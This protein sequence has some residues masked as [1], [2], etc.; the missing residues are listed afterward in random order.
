MAT[1]PVTTTVTELPE[2][3]VRVQAEVA[4]EEIERRVAQ[5]AKALGRSLR[6]PGFRAGKVPPPVI[7]KRV[8]REAVLDEAVRDSLARWYSAAIDD[9]HI[10]PIGEP[11]LNLG[12]L[13]GEGQPL[14]FSIEVGVRPTAVLGRY[15]G[16][17]V[18]R[19]EPDV[20]DEAVQKELDEMRERTATLE[21]V[22]RLHR[23]ATSSSWISWAPSTGCRSR[24]ARAAIS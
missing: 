15:K 7:I 6:V 24:A 20:S 12:D 21:T 23:P 1:V 16:L 14:H 18:V 2:S 3:R 19:R 8:G 5:A 10:V 13:P 9:A 17:D 11:D 22:E 4:P